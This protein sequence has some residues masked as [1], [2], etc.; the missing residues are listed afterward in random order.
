MGLEANAVA[1]LEAAGLEGL[2]ASQVCGAVWMDGLHG[3]MHVRSNVS[4]HVRRLEGSADFSDG[5][6]VF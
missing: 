3:W 1:G 5:V 4:P 2:Q 6:C